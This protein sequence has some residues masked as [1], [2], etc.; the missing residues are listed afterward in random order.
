M[1]NRLTTIDM[2]QRGEERAAVPLLGEG[3]WVPI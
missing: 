3:S 2:S 1:G